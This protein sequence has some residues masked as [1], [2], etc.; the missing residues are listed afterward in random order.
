MVNTPYSTVE[1]Y[2]SDIPAWVP[3]EEQERVSSYLQYDDMYWSNKNAFKLA[4]VDGEEVGPIYVPKAKTI[5]DTT[6]HFLLKGL[7]ITAPEGNAGMTAAL[8]ALFARERFYSRFHIAKHS[9]VS[10]GD[11]LLHMSADEEK[12]EGT[13]LSI[14]TVHPAAWFPV[15][16]D[17]DPDKLKKV[18]LAEI[19]EHRKDGRIAT[20]I[21]RL[22]YEYVTVSGQRRVSRTEG[23]FEERDWFDPLKA[24]KVKSLQKTK[25]L[26]ESI[27]VI[28][29]YRFKNQEWQGEDH[30][31]SELRGFERL[32]QAINQSITDEE[33]ALA[34]EGLGVYAT[35]A[36][37]PINPDTQKRVPWEVAPA[38]VMEL[39]TGSYF[40]RVEGVGS[41]TPMLEHVKY[42]QEAL[43]E[44][45]GT[46]DI[47]RGVVDVQVAQSGIALALKF[48]PTLAKVEERD[49]AGIEGLKQFFH[50][51]KVWH[52]EYEGQNFGE[53]EV[54]IAIGDKL[55][56]DDVKT[57]NELNNMLDR[58]VIDTKF[59]REKMK[60]LGYE[61]PDDIETRIADEANKKF[62][63]AQKMASLNKQNN[64][65][66]ADDPRETGK[67]KSGVAGRPTQAG[68]RT[69]ERQ[70]R[71]RNKSKPNESAG[72]EAQ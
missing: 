27:T 71:S 65:V 63:M 53:T 20:Y 55:P 64:E 11:Y 40:K 44:A 24:R 59:Y 69:R 52:A 9:G 56:H 62:E 15:Y 25:L 3:E 16:D 49:I 28:P 19:F 39:P 5:V 8:E 7:S 6:S 31:T 72:T 61:F 41:I 43:Y 47:S 10:R 26:P 67:G 4:L 50:D 54:V 42:M 17:W 57:V 21:R 1:P 48:L 60:E 68:A 32:M 70:S 33:V 30:G 2:L 29:V 51:W 34:L 36:A 66:T 22:T 23:F 12:P 46:S 18:H 13:R 14:T 37:G 58:G 38:R 35:D 45:S